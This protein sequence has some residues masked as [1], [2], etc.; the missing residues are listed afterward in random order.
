[1]SSEVRVT[2]ISTAAWAEAPNA[3][4]HRMLTPGARLALAFRSIRSILQLGFGSLV[5][6]LV[7]A[8]AMGFHALRSMS[9]EVT[10]SFSQVQVQSQLSSRLSAD[11]AQ[12][13][14]AATLYL[15]TRDRAVLTEFRALGWDA[16]ATQ[17]RMN[18]RRGQSAQEV[19][20][21]ASIDEKLSTVETHFARSHRLADL[22][23]SADA[24]TEAALARP[25][26]TQILADMDRLGEVKARKVADASRSL[27][28]YGS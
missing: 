21:T 19:A 9:R 4:P 18:S 26:A 1:M 11:I 16:H 15:D 7:I 13:L 17:R 12:Q 27:G 22:G 8:G 5:V 2:P 6:L 23:R 14:Q 24:R 3:S 20:L 10:E 28:N 25:I